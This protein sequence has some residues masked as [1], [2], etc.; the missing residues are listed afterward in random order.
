VRLR[1]A[2]ACAAGIAALGLTATP[3]LADDP[4]RPLP[5]YD[6]RPVPAPTPGEVALWIP[7]VLLF[8][9]YVVSEYVIRKPLGAL[10]TAAE[11]NNWATALIDFFTFDPEHKSGL[12]PTAFYDFGLQPSVGL[13]FFWN[14][15]FIRG[16]DLRASVSYF[17]S[18]W[19]ALAGTERFRVGKASWI[20]LNGRWVRRP[21]YTYFGEGARTAESN[22]ADYFATKIDAGPSYELRVAPSVMYR[23]RAGVRIAE[24]HDR[25]RAGHPSVDQQVRARV[26]ALPTDYDKGYTDLYERMELTVDSRAAAQASRTGV[27]AAAHAEH[28][29]DVRRSPASSWITYGGALGGS[30]D[31]WHE[32]VLSLSVSADF[33]DPLR[34]GPIPFSEEVV[35][36]GVEPLSGFIPG[37]LHGRS[38]A[39][40]TLAYTWPIWVWLEGRM[41]MSAG[42]VF[43]AGL[44]DFDTKLLRL[45]GGLGVQ[46]TGDADHRL[47]LLVGFGTETFDQGTKVDSFRLV[48][49]G[50]NGF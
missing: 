20:A 19:V 37:R 36:G 5:D 44:R 35:W 47:E 43:D 31:V 48:L 18:D 10:I 50:T 2:A 28:G 6:G 42:N 23:A 9:P 39:A 3:S 33:A 12:V 49:G 27:R 7:R 1:S 24:F 13:Y 32:R 40:A 4:K 16:H 25:G 22:Q 29:T 14:D 34:N 38:A 45:S 46:S 15:A 30:I 26:F 11:R 41:S 21:D 17:G 8:P